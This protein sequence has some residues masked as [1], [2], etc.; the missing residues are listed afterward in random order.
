MI[1]KHL[2]STSILAQQSTNNRSKHKKKKKL[3]AVLMLTSLVDTFSVLVIYLLVNFSAAGEMLYISKGMELPLASKAEKLDRNIVVKVEKGKIFVE[4][5]EVAQKSLVKKLLAAKEIW[6]K[7][8]PDVE[9]TQALTIQSDK[10][11]TYDLLS[12]VIQAGSHAG[13]SDIHFAVVKK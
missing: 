8:Y 1:E 11:Q 6:E 9:F 12:Y 13:Y 3:A 4:D 10:K 5:E 2:E 7:D